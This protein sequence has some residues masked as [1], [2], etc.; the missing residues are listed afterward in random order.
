MYEYKLLSAL[1]L[2]GPG[3]LLA[4]IYWNAQASMLRPKKADPAIN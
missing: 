2:D 3:R 4:G 1:T